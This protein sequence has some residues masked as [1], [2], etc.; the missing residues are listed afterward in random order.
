MPYLARR[1]GAGPRRQVARG[2]EADDEGSERYVLGI[3]RTG[4]TLDRAIAALSAENEQLQAQQ[5]QMKQQQALQQQ[6]S[7]SPPPP[8]QYYQQPYYGQPQQGYAQKPMYPPD[9]HPY[10]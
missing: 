5:E 2:E 8:G 4:R 3:P 9:N 1:S 7:P 6:Q 10:A